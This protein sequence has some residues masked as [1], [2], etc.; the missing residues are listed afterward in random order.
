M[1]LYDPQDANIPPT[2]TVETFS[3]PPAR[4]TLLLDSVG[5]DAHIISSLNKTR[6]SL[7]CCQGF[8]G[9][10]SFLADFVPSAA[11][12]KQQDRRKN[13]NRPN[14]MPGCTA[15]LQR[16]VATANV[17]DMQPRGGRKPQPATVE[18]VER[19]ER[20]KAWISKCIFYCTF[21]KRH[22]Y[23]KSVHR[24]VFLFVCF[25]GSI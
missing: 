5:V 8:A 12:S 18:A 24:H 9:S 10:L 13:S 16:D 7:T 3:K 4:W 19:E 14:Q 6:L 15:R 20:L 22:E 2:T 25:G 23:K 1:G 11:G 17:P 21:T